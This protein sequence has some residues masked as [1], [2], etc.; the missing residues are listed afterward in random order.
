MYSEL[1]QCI[2][3]IQRILLI[4]GLFF[5]EGLATDLLRYW[6]NCFSSKATSTEVFNFLENEIRNFVQYFKNAK[7]SP[8]AAE[9]FNPA[10][11]YIESFVSK[12]LSRGTLQLISEKSFSKTRKMIGRLN[13]TTTDEIT[14]RF[15]SI[16][17]DYLLLYLLTKGDSK[18]SELYA[19]I[20]DKIFDTVPSTT[21]TSNLK[22]PQGSVQLGNLFPGDFITG[23]TLSSFS[24]A[25]QN[26][27]RLVEH[28]EQGLKNTVVLKCYKIIERNQIL[29]RNS[30]SGRSGYIP[31]TTGG[32]V[33]IP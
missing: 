18:L 20:P 19:K 15:I 7:P 2:V 29:D 1:R 28:Y 9:L 33:V 8:G 10:I 6:Y 30:I 23:R 14:T 5:N 25:Y 31:S 21:S 17:Y 12:A 22:P 32:G 16:A 11:L 24:N 3:D 26:Y 13:F 27:K 4:D